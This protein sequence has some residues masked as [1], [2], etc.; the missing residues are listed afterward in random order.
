MTA[1]LMMTGETTEA[2][3]CADLP[4]DQRADVIAPDMAWVESAI[5]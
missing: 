1:V 4:D 3:L 5:F 2:M